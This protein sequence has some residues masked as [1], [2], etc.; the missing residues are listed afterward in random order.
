MIKQIPEDFIGARLDKWLK[1]EVPA[2]KQ[3][4]IEMMLRKG[5]IR[6]NGVKVKSSYRLVGSDEVLYP[7]DLGEIKVMDRPKR[8]K[9][10]VPA[11]MIK[12]LRKC[13]L[14]EDDDILV[15]NKPAGLS[16]QG[17]TGQTQHLDSILEAM[18]GPGHGAPKLV[19]R[20]DKDTSGVMVV[21]KNLKTAQFLTREFSQK[22]IAKIYWAIV[23][24]V[25]GKREGE[26][27]LPLEKATFGDLEK[28]IVNEDGKYAST[29]YRVKDALGKAFAWLELEPHTGRTH[30]LRVHCAD[31]RGL[32]CPI[33]G[34]GKYG[35]ERAHPQGREQLHLH[36]RAITF[37]HPNGKTMTF[38]AELPH[39]MKAT[40]EKLGLSIKG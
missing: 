38:Q 36:A 31:T 40:W 9:L 10:P 39:H 8:R 34:D 18:M 16:A 32:N 4:M 30:Q 1:H 24:G 3:G 33:L 6:V 23:V 27:Q 11:Q 14:Y 7:D 25:P 19:H 5:S 35:G 12:D 2:L 15:I 21:A 29:Y 17:G 22:T 13:I 28:I 37:T 20:L 26:V